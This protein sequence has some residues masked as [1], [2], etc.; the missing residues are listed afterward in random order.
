[1]TPPPKD[2]GIDHVMKPMSLRPLHG[3]L[4]TV[5]G[6]NTEPPGVL[7]LDSRRVH[8]DILGALTSSRGTASRFEFAA[9]LDI[10]LG[11][12]LSHT[13]FTLAERKITRFAWR[14][15]TRGHVPRIQAISAGFG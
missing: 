2:K 8:E 1:M 11:S 13:S 12:I 14:T 10:N 7:P 4:A 15:R 3:H 5:Y 9:P 6:R